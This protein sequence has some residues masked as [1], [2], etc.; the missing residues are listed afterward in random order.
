[1]TAP[2]VYLAKHRVAAVRKLLG[3]GD[4]KVVDGAD[5]ITTLAKPEFASAILGFLRSVHAK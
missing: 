2:Q 5:H 4:L 1:M 3:H